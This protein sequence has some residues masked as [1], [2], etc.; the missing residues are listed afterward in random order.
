[1][2]RLLLSALAL[3]AGS[4][5][6]GSPTAAN[7]TTL[8]D[9]TLLA[10]Q[11]AAYSFD[12]VAGSGSTTI[13]FAGYDFPSFIGVIDIGL[14][15]FG[16]TTNLLGAT[17]NFTPA[18]CGSFAIQGNLGAFGTSNLTFGGVCSGSYDS[19]AQ[20]IG[21]TAGNTYTLSFVVD[22]LSLSDDGLR[23]TANDTPVPDAVPEP[24]TWAMMLI[25]FGAVG[26]AT[27]RKLRLGPQAA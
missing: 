4:A 11:I 6:L 18:P 15:D 5:V 20:T 3:A 25:G 24:A 13:E 10:P 12:F 27:R 22:N 23:V 19:F 8:F 17:F 1:M 16:D 14:V 9:Q 2:K 21:T 26:F 7:A